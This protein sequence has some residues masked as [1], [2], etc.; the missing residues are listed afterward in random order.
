[1]KFTVMGP[2]PH[3]DLEISGAA[4]V[5]GGS[6]AIDCAERQKDHQV[7][8]DV[9][10]TN[11]VLAEGAGEAF[12]AS[13][14]IPPRVYSEAISDTEIDDDGRPLMTREPVA[15]DGNSVEVRLWTYPN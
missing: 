5:V 9:R 10:A 3:V 13:F 8:I 6:V 4:A 14:I 11:G 7:V 12:V 15:L 2:G 1:M